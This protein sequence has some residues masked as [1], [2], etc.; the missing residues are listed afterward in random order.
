[1]AIHQ[2]HAAHEDR[3]E[4]R[5]EESLVEKEAPGDDRS[6]A[7]REELVQHRVPR[8][9]SGGNQRPSKS[10][11]GGEAS[12]VDSLVAL[13]GEL[14]E[15]ISCAADRR[16]AERL[17]SQRP[18]GQLLAVAAPRASEH[19]GEGGRDEELDEPD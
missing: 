7:A 9:Q 6:T 17:D 19:A 5:G 14:T 18:R 3:D 11:E 8:V 12:P 16:G 15:Q 13:H 1:M 10:R 2:E 4:E